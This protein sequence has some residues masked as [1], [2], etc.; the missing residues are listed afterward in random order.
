[1]EKEGR[2]AFASICQAKRWSADT[3]AAAMAV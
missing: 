2:D 3:G 1:M